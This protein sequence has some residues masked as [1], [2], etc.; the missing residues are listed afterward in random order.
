MGLLDFLFRRTPK[1]AGAVPDFDI[2]LANIVLNKD[3]LEPAVYRQIQHELATKGFVDLTI[4]LPSEDADNPPSSRSGKVAKHSMAVDPV[5]CSIDYT[6]VAGNR[7]RRRITTRSVQPARDQSIIAA[8]CH[9]RQALRHFRIDRIS[10]IVTQ[11]GEIFSATDFVT[12][13]LGVDLYVDQ[14]ASAARKPARIPRDTNFSRYTSPS[15]IVL[16]ATALADDHLHQEEVEVILRYLE[17]DAFALHR[18]GQISAIPD[19]KVFDVIGR[20]IKR[21]RPTK[22]DLAA[23]FGALRGRPVDEIDRL[24]STVAKVIAADGQVLLSEEMFLSELDSFLT[25]SNATAW[26]ELDRLIAVQ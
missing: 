21:L 5:F 3:T 24:K 26:A 11:D 20:R 9:E 6:D 1:E 12:N 18:A 2:T 8:Y 13:I 23:A 4:N 10:R 25:A 19:P 17:D 15:V 22:E 14:P 7:S 16:A